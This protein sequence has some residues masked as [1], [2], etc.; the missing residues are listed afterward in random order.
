M[1]MM[2]FSGLILIIAG[3]FVAISNK[4]TFPLLTFISASLVNIFVPS[5]GGQWSVQGKTATEYFVIF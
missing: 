5:C 4:Y 3:G 1:G 2:K